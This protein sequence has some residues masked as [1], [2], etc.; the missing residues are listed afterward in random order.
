MRPG[1]KLTLEPVKGYSIGYTLGPVGKLDLLEEGRE[2]QADGAGLKIEHG[3]GSMESSLLTDQVDPVVWWDASAGNEAE[4]GKRMLE[5][6][7]NCVS[8]LLPIGGTTSVRPVPAKFSGNAGE[9]EDLV[10]DMVDQHQ[11]SES[12]GYQT[13]QVLKHP[14]REARLRRMMEGQGPAKRLAVVVLAL[15]GDKEGTERLCKLALSTTGNEQVDLV[16]VLPDMPHSARMLE[17]MVNLITAKRNY[18]TDAGPGVGVADVDRR[19]ALI[20][21]VMSY[22]PAEVQPFLPRLIEWAKQTNR[23]DLE[24]R[25][26]GK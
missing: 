20:R 26:E 3:T 5:P 25:F 17:T 12:S 23:K 9:L 16:S 11:I 13:Y 1:E 19:E 4:V 7:F 21:S 14:A 6:R 2:T 15:T 8:V 22:P 18:L 24:K 10:L